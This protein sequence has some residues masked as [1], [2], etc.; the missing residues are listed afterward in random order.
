MENII[1]LK[2]QKEIMFFKV[3]KKEYKHSFFEN[4][5]KKDKEF[6]IGLSLR[7]NINKSRKKIS[8]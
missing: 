1:L 4:I 5:E 8:K 7:Q 6:F 3:L 2:R